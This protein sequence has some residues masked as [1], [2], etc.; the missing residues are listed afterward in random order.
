MNV[1][2]VPTKYGLCAVNLRS[3]LGADDKIVIHSPLALPGDVVVQILGNIAAEAADYFWEVSRWASNIGIAALIWAIASGLAIGVS[4]L[5]SYPAKY[6]I[7]YMPIKLWFFGEGLVLLTSWLFKWGH[8]RRVR[9]MQRA[10]VCH[11]IVREDWPTSIAFI[12]PAVSAA[13]VR[14][15]QEAV[16]GFPKLAPYYEQML[17]IDKPILTEKYPLTILKRLVY[18]VTGWPIQLPRGIFYLGDWRKWDVH[19]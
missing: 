1:G 8:R 10:L 17:Q 3:A 4:Q 6:I 2:I 15:L 9:A 14:W 5:W 13:E 7:L 16:K 18:C 19:D 12:Y 11:D